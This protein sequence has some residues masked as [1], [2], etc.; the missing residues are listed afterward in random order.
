M[1]KTINV[2]A[3]LVFAPSLALTACN[4]DNVLR[5]LQ[6]NAPKASPFCSTYTLPPPNQPLPTYVSQYPASRVSSGCSCLSTTGPTAWTTSATATTATTPRVSSSSNTRTSTTATATPT[7]GPGQ[8]QCNGELVR[9]GGFQFTSS[10]SEA[11]PWEFAL[12][13]SPDNG[14]ESG[15]SLAFGADSNNYAC[16][17]TF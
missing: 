9:N 8:L 3:L 11:P 4:A 16:A 1:T 12:P 15:A 10:A 17:S 7:Y 2:A 14:R 13:L 5:A 6:A